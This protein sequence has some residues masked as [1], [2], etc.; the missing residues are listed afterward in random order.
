LEKTDQKTASRASRYQGIIIGLTADQDDI[1][2]P[3]PGNSI[4]DPPQGVAT[5]PKPQGHRARNATAGKKGSARQT[6]SG[7]RRRPGSTSTRPGNK[8]PVDGNVKT[9]QPVSRG[10]SKKASAPAGRKKTSKSRSSGA[11]QKGTLQ[12]KAGATRDD[13]GRSKS[14]GQKRTGTQTASGTGTAST[15]AAAAK[16]AQKST[17]K[18]RH[19]HGRRPGRETRGGQESAAKPETEVVKTAAPTL[20]TSRTES[21]PSLSENARTMLINAAFGDECR[22]A[23]LHE[24]RLE[25][26]FIERVSS[27]SHV[28]NIYKG[29]VTNVEPSIQACFIDFGAPKHGFLH[30][31]D[32]AAVF[33]GQVRFARRRRPQDPPP[34]TPADS[35]VL[36]PRAG[37]H[38]S[39]HQ[40]GHGHEGPDPDDLSV[41]PRSIP[42][43]D[44]RHEPAGRVAQ[45][46][47]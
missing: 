47:G 34:R 9:E 41:H 18:D 37:G 12:K 17:G 14:A 3:S 45:N 46:R 24:K 25:E 5:A 20:T 33:P 15:S 4:E 8:K 36:P 2:G 29:I 32:V 13:R 1:D 7:Q 10:N 42:C 28:G 40:G 22:I 19:K 23:V 43:H 38:R 26:L 27:A 44:A 6:R 35:I 31:S 39:D 21:I 16:D 11:S 30:I